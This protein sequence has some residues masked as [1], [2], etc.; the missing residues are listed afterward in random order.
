MWPFG[1]CDNGHIL[2][3]PATA[4]YQL[5]QYC[6]DACHPSVPIQHARKQ[7]ISRLWNVCSSFPLLVYFDFEAQ[8]GSIG[9]HSGQGRGEE[10]SGMMERGYGESKAGGKQ[11]LLICVIM[12]SH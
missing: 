1:H 8:R 4:I 7:Y 11:V 9:G 2:D 12:Q 5:D 6:H 10:K 3:F